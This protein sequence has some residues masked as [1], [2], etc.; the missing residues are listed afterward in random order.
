MAGRYSKERPLSVL[1]GGYS[2][3][4]LPEPAKTMLKLPTDLIF[5][6]K[7]HMTYK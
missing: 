3:N 6:D 2:L 7:Y 4:R 1:A 5:L